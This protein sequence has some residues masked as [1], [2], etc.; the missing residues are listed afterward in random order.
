MNIKA[1]TVGFV[2]AGTALGSG[3]LTL[4][5]ARGAAWIGQPLELVVPVQI[6]SA[7]A[8]GA[9]CA[10]ADVFHGDSRQDSSRVQVVVS[11]TE[12]ADVLSLKISSS[13]LVD[14]P[15]VTIYL[16]AGC[17]QKSSRKY[18][19]LAD[20]PNDNVAPLSRTVS[21]AAPATPLVIPSEAA[22]QSGAPDAGGANATPQAA[23]NG[24]A[25]SAKASLP[26]STPVAK[27]ASKE[28]SKP[29][30]KEM[31]KE[32]APKKE[33]SAKATEAAKPASAGKPRLRLDPIET[34]N[35][36]VKTLESSTAAATVPDEMARDAQKMQALQGDLKTLLD[37]AVK[38]E[39]SLMAM[40]ERLEKAESERV[41]VALVYGLAALVLLCLGALAFLLT[42]RPRALDWEHAAPQSAHAPHAAASAAVPGG[43]EEDSKNINVD[44]VD[45]DDEAFDQLM[46]Q[47]QAQDKSP[48]RPA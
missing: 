45:M 26:V 46:A 25:K 3:A 4:G 32:P 17:A 48:A 43:V 8:E 2:L 20:F 22:P 5:R 9:V 41:P 31:P 40:R 37:Q 15:V 6:D 16:R 33:S 13:A 19:L 39:A 11:P 36:R 34:L 12:Q 18:V 47:S 10:E 27:A 44:L 38:N 14:E 7:Q 35:E 23:P 1:V 42:R 28:L 24:P 29:A 30:P 21:P